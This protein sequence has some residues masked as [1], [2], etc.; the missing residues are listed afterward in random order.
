MDLSLSRTRFE[1][2]ND[3]TFESYLRYCGRG[4]IFIIANRFWDL[5]KETI[6]YCLNDC[7]VLYNIIYKFSYYI[8]RLFKL[9]IHSYPTLPSLAFAIFRSNFLDEIIDKNINIPQ[10][11]GE[12]YNDIRSGYTGGGVDVYVPETADGKLAYYYDFN[13][14]YPSVMA[15]YDMPVGKCTYFKGEIRKFD[16]DAFGFF[17]CKIKTPTDLK[18]IAYAAILQTRVKTNDGIRTVAALGQYEDMLFSE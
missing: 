16:Q 18:Y 17:F 6:K 14:L 8:F 4:A 3:I 12:V 9:N 13:S 1:Y 2:F 10:I 15:K 5:R 11:A 7:I